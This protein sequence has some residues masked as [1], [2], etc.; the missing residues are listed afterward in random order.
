[1]KIRHLLL[2]LVFA[3]PFAQTIK[4]TIVNLETDDKEYVVTEFEKV[5]LSETLKNI[6]E[7][8]GEKKLE[9]RREGVGLALVAN[10]GSIIP[11]G[12][13]SKNQLELAFSYIDKIFAIAKTDTAQGVININKTRKIEHRKTIPQELA[14]QLKADNLSLPRLTDLLWTANYLEINILLPASS[15]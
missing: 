2:S 12:V 8:L 4:S 15:D 6:L 1:M 7:D 9:R 5:Y 3:L 14:E 10:R 13:L 11:V